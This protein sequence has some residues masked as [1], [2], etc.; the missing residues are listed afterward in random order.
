MEG[1][2]TTGAWRRRL[3]KGIA[4]RVHQNLTRGNVSRAA[5]A[6]EASA[7]AEPTEQVLT[8]LEVLHPDADPPTVP[9]PPDVPPQCSR[10]QLKKILKTLPRG[11]AP[12]PSGWT[13]EHIQAV[14]QGTQ[15]G[16]DAVLDLVNAVLSGPLPAWEALRASRLKPLRKGV[17]CVRQIAVGEVWL[18]LHFAYGGIGVF[19]TYSGSHWFHQQC[20]NGRCKVKHTSGST[21]VSWREQFH[22]WV[23][24]A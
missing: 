2:P 9:P 15:E 7:V 22:S 1:P 3:E 8:Q 12:G 4:Q 20:R 6:F 17:D 14:A 19:C 23:F 24:L 11:S 16:M 5:K 18:R 10:Q 13:F 21:Q